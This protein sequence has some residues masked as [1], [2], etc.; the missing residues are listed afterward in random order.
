MSSLSSLYPLLTRK[1][2][3]LY[4]ELGVEEATITVTFLSPIILGAVKVVG[5]CVLY[6]GVLVLRLYLRIASRLRSLGLAIEDEEVR[7]VSLVDEPKVE[8]VL[9]D[10]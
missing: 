5:G 9:C 8:Y 7:W 1:V 3:I 6:D 4:L 10:H 2:E